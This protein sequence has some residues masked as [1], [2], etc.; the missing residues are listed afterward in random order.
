MKNKLLLIFTPWII[1]FTH[2]IPNSLSRPCNLELATPAAS[3]VAQNAT[4]FKNNHKGER[5]LNSTQISRCSVK[6]S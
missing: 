1:P 4:I 6:K 5:N 3:Y 2:P